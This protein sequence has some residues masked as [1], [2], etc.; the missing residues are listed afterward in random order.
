MT[1]HAFPPHILAELRAADARRQQL[2]AEWLARAALEQPREDITI[3][4]RRP[5]R[6]TVAGHDLD[7]YAVAVDKPHGLLG[8]TPPPPIVDELTGHTL[9]EFVEAWRV[10]AERMLRQLGEALQPGLEHLR[11]QL[12]ELAAAHPH[13]LEQPGARPPMLAALEAKRVRTAGPPPPPLD[14]RRRR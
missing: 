1:D 14:R 6:V 9:A 2:E 11:A 5:D 10:L 7:E 12:D 8:H 4:I 13:L 3:R